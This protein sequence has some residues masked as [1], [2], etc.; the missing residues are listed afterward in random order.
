[1]SSTSYVYRKEYDVPTAILHQFFTIPVTQSVA[2]SD[3]FNTPSFETRNEAWGQISLK[4]WVEKEIMPQVLLFCI[5]IFPNKTPN[6]RQIVMYS[7]RLGSVPE[8]KCVTECHRN[9]VYRND[10][11]PS[12]LLHP[13]ITP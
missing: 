7:M 1:M 5:L 9:P 4:Y 10:D 2:D 13:Y 3:G 12:A 11:V 8:M 6:R